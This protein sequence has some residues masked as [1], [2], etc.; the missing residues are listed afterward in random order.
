MNKSIKDMLVGVILGDAH[1]KRIGLNKAFISFEQSNK[2]HEYINYLHNL[3]KEG[4]I[5]LINE[6]LKEYTRNDNRHNT[7]NKSLYFKTQNLDILRPIADLF[8]DENDKKI[9]P[10]NIKDFLTPR[11]LAF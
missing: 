2:K 4:G 1:I 3:T 7:I 10:N 8:L 11:S 5:D 6:E 9:I